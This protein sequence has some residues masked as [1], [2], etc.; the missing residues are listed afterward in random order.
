MS[1]T[2]HLETD[3]SSEWTNKTVIHALHYQVTRNQTG[4][5]HLG[6]SPLMILPLLSAAADDARDTFGDKALL[7]AELMRAIYTGVMEAQ[8]N[9]LAAKVSQAS[10]A[11]RHRGADPH[12]VVRTCSEVTTGSPNSCAVFPS[13]S[14]YTLNLPGSMNI[15]PNFMSLYCDPS[16][17]MATPL[18]P[19][20]LTPAP[21]RLSQTTVSRSSKSTKLL[22]T[23]AVDAAI[24]S[25]FVGK[26][27]V[28]EMILG[29]RVLD[30][31][32]RLRWTA[33]TPTYICFCDR[34]LTFL[35]PYEHNP[36]FCCYCPSLVE[37]PVNKQL[38]VYPTAITPTTLPSLP[39]PASQTQ[40]H[41]H[42]QAYLLFLHTPL[43]FSV[44]TDEE[45]CDLFEVA[46]EGDQLSLDLELDIWT[47]DIHNKNSKNTPILGEGKITVTSLV[48]W[49]NTSER[50][51][52]SKGTDAD[53]KVSTAVLHI[54]N[55]LVLQWYNFFWAQM[56]RF[57]EIQTHHP[58][59]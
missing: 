23:S 42:T 13:S 28:L 36:E 56:C 45:V 47:I 37:G 32:I 12:G 18:I 44:L 1:T 26:D 20:A 6:C 50:Y 49:E 34:G 58:C 52:W 19:P 24:N 40:G 29:S 11:N 25:L 31:V 16:I 38:T 8:D 53:K 51:F 57:Q 30:A 39:P 9:L 3:R 21:V 33:A 59:T 54:E 7:A 43:P 41:V 10:S 35:S 46:A 2:F 5:L 48:A 14:V 15:F 22:I 17:Q 55:K 27:M 4:W